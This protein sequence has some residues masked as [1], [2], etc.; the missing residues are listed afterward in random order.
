MMMLRLG[1]RDCD[2]N[3]ATGGASPRFNSP[4]C[5]LLDGA[6]SPRDGT[7]MTHNPCGWPTY[8]R[9][10][11]A[12]SSDTVPPHQPRHRS[13]D[14]PLVKRNSN[15]AELWPGSILHRTSLA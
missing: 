11:R 7:Y 9:G 5:M 1:C 15:S 14:G 4:D 10:A 3:R 12:C 13:T 6:A 8:G 2:L